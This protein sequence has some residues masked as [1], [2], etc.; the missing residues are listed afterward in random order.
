MRVLFVFLLM[1][2]LV[3]SQT[4]S[5]VVEYNNS[6]IS[7]FNET[8]NAVLNFNTSL[9]QGALPSELIQKRDAV[10]ESI[11]SLED[12][13]SKVKPMANDFGL[14]YATKGG[15]ETY[16]K[17]FQ[18]NYTDEKLSL[19]PAS[20]RENIAKIKDAQM[21]SEK[22]DTWNK[23]FFTRQKKLLKSHQIELNIDTNMVKRINEHRAAMDY[24]Y[25]VAL[26]ELNVQA[27]VDDFV[28]AFNSEN[29]EKI[30]I[31]QSNLKAQ[32]LISDKFMNTFKPYKK[33]NSLLK[34]S[35]KLIEMYKNLSNGLIEDV[36]KLNSFSEEIPNERVDEYNGLVDKVNIGVKY[37]NT[38]QFHLDESQIVINKFFQT[39]LY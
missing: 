7:P 39:H 10:L 31:A 11:N 29:K 19:I 37:L 30:K 28:E 27:F 24:Y 23:D 25:E 3:F 32:I 1:P 22:M 34:S 20:S 35:N 13:L 38:L 8:S 2:F 21:A 17:Y 15:A 26:N 36:I 16:K 5:E 14:Y 6:I 33:D 4:K 9:L 18:Q 12:I